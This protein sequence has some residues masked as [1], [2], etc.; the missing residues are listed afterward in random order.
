MQVVLLY[1]TAERTEV[2]EHLAHDALGLHVHVD[3]GVD[4]GKGVVRVVNEI[5]Q[6]LGVLDLLEFFHALVIFHALRLEFVQAGIAGL[7]LLDAQNRVRVLD[8]AFA[9]GNHVKR[10][11]RRILVEFRECVEQV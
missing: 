8:D 11:L 2:L 5:A 7:V 1:V 10:V 4:F 9:Q 3:P 6:R